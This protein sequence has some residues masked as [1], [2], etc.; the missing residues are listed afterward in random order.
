M[1][2]PY[3]RVEHLARSILLS[4]F[5]GSCQMAMYSAYFDES[6]HPDRGPYLIVAGC[7]GDVDQWVEFEREWLEALAPLGTTIFHAVDFDQRNPPFDRLT[8]RDADDLLNR[9]VGIICRRINKS[10]SHVTPLDQYRAIN[11]KYLFAECYGYPYPSAARVCLG[12]VGRWASNY[13]VAKEDLLYFFEDGAKH[14][15]QLEWIAERDG[16]PIPVFRKKTEVVPLQVGDLIAWCSHLYLTS[17]KHIPR[18]YEQALD[19]LSEMPCEWG[20]SQSLQDLDRLP[21]ILRIPLRDP[22]LLYKCVIVKKDG[23]RRALV[24]YWPKDKVLQPK[25]DRKTLVLPE[26]NVLSA[27]DVEKAVADYEAFRA[28]VPTEKRM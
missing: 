11:N 7:V 28:A 10:F 14:K 3:S 22:N 20:I 9:L 23:H 5:C 8:D 13:S 4:R 17:G 26:Q 2:Q 24:H 15:G 25:I 6:G 1:T 16:L 19:R 12:L 21:T 18:R 27:T